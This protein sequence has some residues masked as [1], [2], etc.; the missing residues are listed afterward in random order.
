LVLKGLDFT[1]KAKEGINQGDLGEGRRAVQEERGEEVVI[2]VECVDGKEKT[3]LV[4]LGAEVRG[5]GG[6]LASSS[7]CFRLLTARLHQQVLGVMKR[8]EACL[9]L[10]PVDEP[11]TYSRDPELSR[12]KEDDDDNT[13]EPA[14]PDC[15]GAES[16]LCHASIQKPK[17]K[18]DGFFSTPQQESQ[19]RGAAK[20]EPSLRLVASS[21]SLSSSSKPSGTNPPVSL[22]AALA[23]VCTFATKQMCALTALVLNRSVLQLLTSE[24]SILQ[25]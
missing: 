11:Q 12:S 22:A 7:A 13:N 23:Q 21:S 15:G 9:C 16:H 24:M 2:T 4:H 8:S 10:L 14:S 20:S 25:D 18:S 19:G 3:T 1:T 17:H 6:R 5:G